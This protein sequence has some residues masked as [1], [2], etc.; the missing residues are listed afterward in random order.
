MLNIVG[1]H[2]DIVPPKAVAALPDLLSN[3]ETTTM[4]FPA[5]H[6]GLIVGRQAAKTFIP[7]VM[8][9]IQSHSE[10]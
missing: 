1:D 8:D 3:A 5:G 2:D 7:A 6:V 4:M 10:T 9:W